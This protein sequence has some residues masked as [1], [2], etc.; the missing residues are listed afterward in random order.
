M[1][2]SKITLR[3]LLA[4]NLYTFRYA[5]SL[6]PVYYTLNILLN[7]FIRALDG[8]YIILLYK[9]QMDGVS[10]NKSFREMLT[11]ILFY[12]VLIAAIVIAGN[13]IL[14]RI[15]E[16]KTIEIAG[17]I[18]RDIIKK[19][20]EL[21]VVY[22]DN[23]KFYD[24]FVRVAEQ[25][26]TQIVN[27]IHLVIEF[28]ARISSLG[29][30]IGVIMTIDPIVAIFPILASIVCVSLQLWVA[31]LNYSLSLKLDPIRHKKEY[32]TR[33]FYRTE[34]AKELK[35]TEIKEPL[36]S[37][38]HETIRQEK[39]YAKKYGKKV[40]LISSLERGIGW[41]SLVYYFP[42]I[43]LI[44]RALVKKS[45][46]IGELAA[47]NE[48]V[49]HMYSEL[50]DITYT[51]IKMQ[52]VGLFTEKFRDFME[53]KSNVEHAAGE[54]VLYA[55]PECLQVEH[56]HF[57]YDEEGKEVLS[58]INMTVRPKEKIAIVGFNGAG[59]TTFSKLLLRLYEPTEGRILYG[60]KDIKEYSTEAYRKQFGV[61]FQD[62]QT[63]AGTVGENIQMDHVTGKN[64][65]AIQRALDKI[66]LNSRR[67]NSKFNIETGLTREFDEMGTLL[68]GGENQ[69]LSFARLLV[70]KHNIVILDEPSSALDPIAEYE[71]NENMLEL[72]KDSTVIFIAH[73]LASTRLADKVY[74]FE[75][76]SVI[77][78]G[79]HDELMSLNG[80]YAEMYRKQAYYYQNA[81][82][83]KSSNTVFNTL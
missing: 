32:F 25:G 74:L 2:E 57:R 8:V 14:A 16:V 44:Y 17:Q 55:S 82:E 50:N 56:V 60:G 15:D 27:A 53:I 61:V 69:K 23:S 40:C 58:D 42:P 31:R 47:M 51:F 45:I 49:G 43:Y 24:D 28:I 36:F 7:S 29:A 48:S 66:G 77:E 63:Y 68:S 64:R 78:E 21:D 39:S 1:E 81:F 20:S 54:D 73:R 65:A 11:V 71:L 38:F 35:L 37:M 79:T 70:K 30:L 52:D 33:V 75:H 83:V 59:K 62:F 76:G 18:Q 34:Y 72:S 46:G 3:R 10:S 80:K 22:Y 41:I 4:N 5:F 13:I 67:D 9:A 26:E 6:A 12:G 19:A